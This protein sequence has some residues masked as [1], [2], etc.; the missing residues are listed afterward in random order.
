MVKDTEAPHT[1]DSIYPNNW[2]SFHSDGSIYLY[3][4]FAPNRR[5]ERKQTVLNAIQQRFIS[6]QMIDLTEHEKEQ[7]FLEGTGSMVLDRAHRIA[8]ACISSRTDIALVKDFCRMSD[9]RPVT[10][11][12]KDEAGTPI[13][14]TNVLM[15]VADHYAVVCLESISGGSERE[16]LIASLD[17]TG[18]EVIDISFQ[19]LHCFAGNMLQVVNTD[20][21]RG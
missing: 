11:F 1:P 15:C 16:A 10:F 12:A 13:Y 3:P 18:K 9:F 14:H 20:G 5:S 21:E 8:Y 17:Q 7:R 19:Q 4:M 2:I 6:T